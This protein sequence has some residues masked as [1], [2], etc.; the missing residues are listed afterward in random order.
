[1]ES[2]KSWVEA[3]HQDPKACMA[4]V[5]ERD[6]KYQLCLK[7]FQELFEELHERYRKLGISEEVF[8]GAYR[9][10][11]VWRETFRQQH[12]G[13]DGLANYRWL[14]NHLNMRVFGLG[15]LDFEPVSSK[16]KIALSVHIPQGEP[17]AYDACQASYRQAYAFFRGITTRFV[18]G[19][20]LLSPVL[21]ELLPPD[22]NIIRFQKDFTLL[23][24]EPDDRQC[25]QRVFGA[26]SDDYA[27]YPQNTRLQR[28]VRERL[29]Q[30]GKIGK[31]HGEFYYQPQD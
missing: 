7:L 28:A 22:S 17:L 26:L 3:Y 13:E 14:E 21:Q 12:N 10:L 25:E 5:L 30:G 1:M 6:D 19:S 4:Q 29:L 15:R 2:I 23:E 27:S 24:V 11:E 31:G 18:C 9:D 8:R 20:W 16:G